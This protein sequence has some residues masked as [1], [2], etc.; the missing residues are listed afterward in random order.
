MAT[1]TSDFFTYSATAGTAKNLQK[2]QDGGDNNQWGNFI[3]VDLDEI[4]AAVNALAD[5]IAD[6]NEK[7]LVNFTATG[8]AVNHVEITNAATGNPPQISSAGS[9]TNVDLTLTA[10]GT[11]DINLTPGT[12]GDVNIPA[13]KGIVFGDDGEKIE[14]DGTD[15][16]IASSGEINVNS[17]TLDLSAQTVD[18]TLNNAVDALNFDSNT[19]S[20]DASNNRIG[21]GTAA[22]SVALEIK[23]TGNQETVAGFG[24]N[25]NGTAFISVRTAE[26]QN[27]T[28]GIAFDTGTTTP[29]GVGS[30]K[31]LGYMLGKV[32]NSSGA[33]QGELQFWTNDGD[34]LAQRMVITE[35][36][37]V[38]I[39]SDNPSTLIHVNGPHASVGDP[40]A[41]IQATDN[42]QTGLG[43]MAYGSN[44]SHRNWLVAANINVAG[45][46]GIGYT[47]NDSDLPT[48]ANTSSALSITS[49]GDV[50]LASGPLNID[51]SG[52]SQIGFGVSGSAGTAHVATDCGVTGILVQSVGSFDQS[53]HNLLFFL[54]QGSNV[55][56]ITT[57]G[58]TTNYSTT[59]DY[60]LKENVTFLTGA[61][62]RLNQLKPS[63]FNFITNP[64]KTV[65]GFLAHEV[66][67][68]VPEA[69]SGQKDGMRTETYEVTAEVKDENNNII[70]EA[71]IGEREV[72]NYQAI[73]QSKL[74][75]L[76]VASIQE[77]SAKVTAL[78]NA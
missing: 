58:S 45:S 20:I 21:I 61:I 77:L 13:S 54:N 68:H 59:S 1:N 39:G 27:N 69:I 71:V 53:T 34:S 65:D 72:P 2:P 43:L 25:D 57:D 52:N 78:E 73:D 47:S 56:E 35:A 66:S 74:V 31:T 5:K 12:N 50:S 26:T 38:G 41:I 8:S 49:S 62:D 44:A 18:V 22:P 30:T 23:D 70:S 24:A 64:D 67:D 63:R 15:L 6:A 51:G 36:G 14:G 28:A 40:L 16:T 4:V 32:M 60:R 10:K 7:T 76:I 75:P 48:T 19:L 33:L 55:G 29:T 9:D 11:G 17:G 3:N 42:D 46:F 37:N